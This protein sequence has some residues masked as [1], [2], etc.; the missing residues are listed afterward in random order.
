MLLWILGYT[1]LFE[2]VCFLYIYIYTYIHTHTHTHIYPGVEFDGSCNSVFSFLRNF[3]TVFHSSYTNLHSHQQC[4]RAPF[5]PHL[6]QYLLFVLFLMIAILTGVR[7][8]DILKCVEESTNSLIPK[9]SKK[10]LQSSMFSPWL[11]TQWEQ[12]LILIFKIKF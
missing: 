1:C 3:H 12:C 9:W 5:S 11:E 8:S 10:G 2:L 7:F 4:T 6:H